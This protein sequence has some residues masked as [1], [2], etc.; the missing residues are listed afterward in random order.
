[1]KI[2]QSIIHIQYI[3][4]KAMALVFGGPAFQK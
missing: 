3:W 2:Y 4:T 1:M